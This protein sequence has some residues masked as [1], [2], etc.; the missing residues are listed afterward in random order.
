MVIEGFDFNMNTKSII[1]AGVKLDQEHFP[2][3]YE[4]AKTHP[5][6]LEATLRS[7]D[8]AQGN[9]SNLRMTAVL[10]ESDLAHG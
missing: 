2:K 7:L 10:L 9:P 6:T 5:E 8:K 3:L 4:W 1:I